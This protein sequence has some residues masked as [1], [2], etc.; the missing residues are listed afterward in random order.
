M[1]MAEEYTR[2]EMSI[3]EHKA[4]FDGFISVSVYSTL[5][6]TVTLLCVI[7]VFG[8]H[9][10]WLT[11]MFVSAIVG[12]LGGVFLKQGAGYWAT[13]VVLAII[14]FITGGLVSLLN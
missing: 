3:S 4:T 13:L 10:H 14:G 7:L 1:I 9:F 5:V 6:V 11:A 12:G 2:G 8:A